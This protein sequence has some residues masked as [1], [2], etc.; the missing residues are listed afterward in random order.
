MKQFK[1]DVLKPHAQRTRP[2]YFGS[3]QIEPDGEGT[4][5]AL[6]TGKTLKERLAMNENLLWTRGEC[7]AAAGAHQARAHACRQPAEGTGG[8]ASQHG[9]PRRTGRGRAHQPDDERVGGPE[10][11]G[12]LPHANTAVDGLLGVDMDGSSDHDS[13]M[14]GN[15]LLHKIGTAAT[16]TNPIVSAA[17]CPAPT[18]ARTRWTATAR[19]LRSARAGP[20]MSRI[21]CINK[22]KGKGKNAAHELPAVGCA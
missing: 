11:A 9:L 15:D 14:G 4:S 21:R 2:V 13:S 12:D 3:S 16:T 19:R 7:A 20:K 5:S 6:A 1:Y 18:R 22:Y 8:G 10:S 17:T